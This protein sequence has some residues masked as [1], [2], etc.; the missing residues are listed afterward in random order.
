MKERRKLHSEWHIIVAINV[1]FDLK[2]AEMWLE[3]I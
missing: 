2:E 3:M 1:P